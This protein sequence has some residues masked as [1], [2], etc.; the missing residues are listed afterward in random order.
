MLTLA[1]AVMTGITPLCYAQEQESNDWT[2]S[3]YIQQADFG[4][5][6][7]DIDVYGPFSAHQSQQ[8]PNGPDPSTTF[9]MSGTDFPGG[10]HYKVCA[11]DTFLGSLSP[12]CI[13]MG[14]VT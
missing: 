9:S 10:Y 6:S 2:L 7:I 12:T 4:S 14:T 11:S 3:V 13:R 8:L 1:L 5:K